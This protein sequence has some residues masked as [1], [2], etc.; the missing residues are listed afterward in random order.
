M[1]DRDNPIGSFVYGHTNLTEM[2]LAF[3]LFW[4]NDVSADKLNMGLGFYG[5][6]FQ[7][8]DLACSK[9]GCLFKGGATKG[10][11]SG[12]S[13][14]L[15]YRKI[16][17]IIKTKNI[18]PVYDK[19]AGVKYITWNTDQWVSYDDV[20]TF[21][22]KKDMASDLG[23]GGYLIWA[24]DQDD[25][26][27]TALQAVISPKE[28]GDLGVGDDPKNWQGSDKRCYIMPCDG[29][30]DAG[31]IRITD[32]K[33]G[34]DNKR[35]KLCCPLSG[36]PDPGECTWRGNTPLCNG[37]CQDNEVMMEMNKWGGDDGD[38]CSDGNKAYCCKSP[39]AE[40]N[41]CYG[42]A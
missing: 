12:G 23:L 24:I 37:H 15:S 16:Q 8:A 30:C 42:R 4:R 29:N 40:E 34:I 27:M 35:S 7:L 36:A 5:R 17:D 33:C 19:A 10:G 18:E 2:E 31:D 21:K 1:W 39:L 14:I 25:E 20:E 11:C 9:P 3:D 38:K 32:Q 26:S 13:G 6:A 28:L 41:Q 22:Q